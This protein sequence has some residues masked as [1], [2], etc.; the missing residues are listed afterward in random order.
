MEVALALE[1]EYCS[2]NWIQSTLKEE[3]E[4][5]I[6]AIASSGHNCSEFTSSNGASLGDR[7]RVDTT[8]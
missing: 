7:H 2:R 6:L 8:G 4:W 1:W 5:E 3:C